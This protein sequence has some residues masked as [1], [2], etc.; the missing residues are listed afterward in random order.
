[1][2]NRMH[3]L[4]ISSSKETAN[5]EVVSYFGYGA[6]R[7]PNM[8]KAI[9]GRQPKGVRSFVRG[10]E[11]CV[12]T[13]NEIPTHVREKLSPSWDEDFKTYFLRPNYKY[14]SKVRGVIWEVTRKER[15]F[16]DNW[17]LTGDWYKIFTF[18]LKNMEQL[19]IQVIPE[20]NIG[21][22]VNGCIYKSFLNSPAKMFRVANRVRHNYLKT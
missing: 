16:I 6:N 14:R 5:A 1:M 13:W 20:P 2:I 12:Q 8:M 22:V 17:E 21:S 11:L 9:I 19:E 15:H 7:N 18:E 4:Q 3:T 10:F